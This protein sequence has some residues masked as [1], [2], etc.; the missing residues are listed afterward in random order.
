MLND[1]NTSIIVGIIVDS[2][3]NDAHMR[4]EEDF[5]HQLREFDALPWKPFISILLASFSTIK[6]QMNINTNSYMFNSSIIKIC[7][8][9]I[10]TQ[11]TVSL[12]Y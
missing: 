2:N 11:R 8:N 9:T 10:S 3:D 5:E 1:I 4:D 12:N 7:N 6:Y